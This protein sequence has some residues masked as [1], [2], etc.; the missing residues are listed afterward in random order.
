MTCSTL[1]SGPSR[2]P[3]TSSG[4]TMLKGSIGRAGFWTR[5][6]LLRFSRFHGS[7]CCQLRRWIAKAALMPVNAV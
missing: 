6:P 5:A 4:A 3:F 2:A 7:D 1:N